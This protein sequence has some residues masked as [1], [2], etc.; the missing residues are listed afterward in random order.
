MPNEN[1]SSFKVEAPT[2]FM[3]PMGIVLSD[4]I[5][6]CLLTTSERMM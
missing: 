4:L 1:Q 5:D 3:A 6:S 2:Y